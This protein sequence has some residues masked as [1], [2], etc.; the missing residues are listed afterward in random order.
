M[1]KVIDI[2]KNTKWKDVKRSLLYYY[3]DQIKNITA[4]EK[5]YNKIKKFKEIEVKD[6]KEY[7]IIRLVEDEYEE[8]YDI[9]TNKYAFSFR[10]WIDLVNLKIKKCNLREDD[11]IAHFIWEI[12]YYGFTEKKIEKEAINIFSKVK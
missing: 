1:K 9:C 2:L 10:P 8:W 11:I 6:K 12:T 5:A 3:P 4:Y 7:I